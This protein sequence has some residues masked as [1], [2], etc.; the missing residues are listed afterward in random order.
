MCASYNVRNYTVRK[1]QMRKWNVRKRTSHNIKAGSYFAAGRTKSRMSELAWLIHTLPQPAL[2]WAYFN[3]PFIST[4]GAMEFPA[5]H[6]CAAWKNERDRMRPACCCLRA[7]TYGLRQ[8]MNR[9]LLFTHTGYNPHSM[10]YFC[11]C[12][13]FT[14]Y[15]GRRSIQLAQFD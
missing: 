8:S 11:D 15:L 14:F 5:I 2:S 7:A 6:L 9:P 10:F 12:R 4:N 1:W 3:F 13:R